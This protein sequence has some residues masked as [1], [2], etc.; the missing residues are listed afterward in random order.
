M[1]M[2]PLASYV[3]RT[4]YPERHA[5]LPQF[6]TSKLIQ[7]KAPQIT[8]FEMPFQIWITSSL[9]LL[10]I[11]G[12]CMP[13]NSQSAFWWVARKLRPGVLPDA[14]FTA[15]WVFVIVV[16]A[17]EGLYATTLARKHHMP[18][19]VGVSVFSVFYW[20]LCSIT[21]GAFRRLLGLPR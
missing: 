9:L 18:W 6:S 5:Q 12:T 3:T 21:E 17:G 11:Y 15:T 8:H 20:Q 14:F 4:L 7:A 10:L 16:H 19:N 1:R 2:R 13:S